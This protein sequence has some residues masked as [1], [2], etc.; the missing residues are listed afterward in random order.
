MSIY[1]VGSSPDDWTPP[2]RR[3]RPPSRSL[4]AEEVEQMRRAVE[5]VKDVGWRPFGT[6]G[7]AW[8]AALD[9]AISEM[10]RIVVQKEGV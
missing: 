8:Q 7:K 6:E 1:V 2:A 3:K 10:D 9:W 5:N 4:L